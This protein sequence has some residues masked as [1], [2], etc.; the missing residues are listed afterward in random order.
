MLIN[1]SIATKDK[2]KQRVAL[3]VD[4]AFSLAAS[5]MVFLVVRYLHED[6]LIATLAVILHVLIGIN[7]SLNQIWR[8]AEAS[9]E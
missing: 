7:R 4:A 3:S 5:L 6:A 1:M 8:L 2:I 9:R